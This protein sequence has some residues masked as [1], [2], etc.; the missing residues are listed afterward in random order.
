MN[1]WGFTPSLFEE[2]DA[3]FIEFLKDR[4]STPKAEYFL[5]ERVGDLV[6]AGRARVK[7]L[8]TEERW[9]GITYKE[10]KPFVEE[11]V[12]GLVEQGVYPSSLWDA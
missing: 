11:A 3:G 5:P 9:F 6:A 8:R 4:G 2:L 12:R 7:I 10:D 1:M